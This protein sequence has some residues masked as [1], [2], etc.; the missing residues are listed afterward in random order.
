MLEPPPC[1]DVAVVGDAA[2]LVL[3]DPRPGAV[4][5]LLWAR[6]GVGFGLLVLEAPTGGLALTDAERIVEALAPP[7]VASAAG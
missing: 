2:V 5:G 6:R 1:P 7:V 3:A 4:A